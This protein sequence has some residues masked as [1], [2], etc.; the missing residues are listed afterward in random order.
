MATR[1]EIKSEVEKVPEQRLEELYC[2]VKAFSQDK[3]AGAKGGFLSRLS[4]IKIDGP[5]DWAA[6]FDQYL[7]GRDEPEYSL[8]LIK[9]PNPE[10]EGK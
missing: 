9:E 8:D 10:Y 5:E 7:Y 3:P 4:R 6:N 1:E 2:V